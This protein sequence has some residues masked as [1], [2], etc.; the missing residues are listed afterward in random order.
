[1]NKLREKM[2]RFMQGRYGVDQF[3]RFL[4]AITLVCMV[5]S[6]FSRKNVF[7]YLAVVLLIYA[8]FRI[9]SKNHTKRYQE[10][11]KYLQYERVVKGKWQK[12]K[13][14]MA[15]RKICHIYKCPKCKQKIRVP[16]GKGKIMITCPK[17]HNEFQKKS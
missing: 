1:M 6:L 15:Q 12:Q 17:C 16:R 5:L 2:I 8:Y 7:Y 10:N 4:M 3:S 13:N 9:F 14:Q 11:Q